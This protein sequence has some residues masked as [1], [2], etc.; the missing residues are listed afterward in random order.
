V[1]V[2]GARY[3]IHRPEIVHACQ[4]KVIT[5]YTE[6]TTEDDVFPLCVGNRDWV[7]D[8]TGR[9]AVI[10]TVQ[11]RL[12]VWLSLGAFRTAWEQVAQRYDAL[13]GINWDEV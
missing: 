4:P 11:R 3:A 12:T 5:I 6:Q 1:V 9:V 7:V 2:E 8:M 10:Q 13:Y